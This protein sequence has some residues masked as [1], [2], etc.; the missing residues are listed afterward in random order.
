[1]SLS[2]AVSVG[3]LL[4]TLGLSPQRPLW[5]AWQA[6]P[7]VVERWKS[8]EFPAT[9]AR[10]KAEGATIYFGDEAGVRWTITPAPPGPGSARR[11]W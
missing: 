7:D 8:E 3:G 10:A 4:R 2:A 11:R 9:R 5:W 6:D 1:M